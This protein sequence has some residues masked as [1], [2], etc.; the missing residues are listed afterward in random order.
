MECVR[1]NAQRVAQE[2]DVMLNAAESRMQ[3]RFVLN[4]VFWTCIAVYHKPQRSW[5]VL[6]L[7]SIASQLQFAIWQINFI[8]TLRMLL[9]VR[10]TPRRRHGY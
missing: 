6:G 9:I 8:A 5:I 3:S 7:I 4:Y 2:T 1:D 10:P